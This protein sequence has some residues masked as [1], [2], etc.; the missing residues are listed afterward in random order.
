[1]VDADDLI[2]SELER[3][4]AAVEPAFPNGRDVLARAGSTRRLL[5]GALVV[6]LVA[7]LVIGPALAF[8]AGVRHFFRLA[9]SPKPVLAQA[10][11]QVSASAPH[12]QI[13]R[14]FVAPSDKGGTCEFRD[15][16]PAG[17]AHCAVAGGGAC[18]GRATPLHPRGSV[19]PLTWAISMSRKPT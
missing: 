18:A 1:M 19:P 9:S 10:V 11:L 3:L 4:A 13:V 16:V 6:A 2:L 8:S 17:S 5:P 15:I 7:A 14:L 12:G